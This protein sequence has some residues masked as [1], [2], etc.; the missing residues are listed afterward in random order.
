[1]DKNKLNDV[2]KYIQE[3][4]AV[5]ITSD[6]L[7]K[8]YDEISQE[9]ILLK[10]KAVNLETKK[11]ILTNELWKTEKYQKIKTIKQKEQETIVDLEDTINEIA[12]TKKQRDLAYYKM[13]NVENVIKLRLA[14]EPL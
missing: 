12:E 2:D 11:E 7:V 3:E 6:K 1:M 14:G 10:Y 4:K 13:K 9:Y 8:L 5:F